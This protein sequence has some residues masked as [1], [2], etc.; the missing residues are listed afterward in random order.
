MK[1]YFSL[2]INVAESAYKEVEQILQ[3]K[4][5]LSSG[6]GVEIVTEDYFDFITH[7]LDIVE[8]KYSQLEKLDISREDI[9]IWCLYQY[10]SQCNLEFGYLD[11]LRLGQNKISLCISC[12][13]GT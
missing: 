7:F 11:L 10:D 9:T 8:N 2:R 5:N 1:Y 12:W 4:A 3:V 13:K 6:W